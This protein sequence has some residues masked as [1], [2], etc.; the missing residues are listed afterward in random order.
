MTLPQT[1]RMKRSVILGLGTEHVQNLLS[2]VSGGG[3][4]VLNSLDLDEVGVGR[5][6][7]EGTLEA[8]DHGLGVKA[9]ALACVLLGACCAVL[10]SLVEEF[11]DVHGWCLGE[12]VLHIPC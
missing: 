4:G 8:H 1:V 10:A 3:G 2:A 12:I 6:S 7:T 11:A 9:G 5:L